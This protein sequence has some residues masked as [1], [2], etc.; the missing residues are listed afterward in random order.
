MKKIFFVLL[1]MQLLSV[2]AHADICAYAPDMDLVKINKAI[3]GVQVSPEAMEDPTFDHNAPI[4]T[5]KVIGIFSSQTDATSFDLQMSNS[6]LP[7]ASKQ[8]FFGA[9]L[10]HFDLVCDDSNGNVTFVNLA[11]A[12][13]NSGILC[14]SPQFAGNIPSSTLDLS[15]K[16]VSNK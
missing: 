11:G 10:G 4:K 3:A 2:A 7:D 6:G 14:A 5:G 8:T 13:K 9:D 16:P 1:S 15:C 12:L